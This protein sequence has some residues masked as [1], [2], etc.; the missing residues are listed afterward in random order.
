M[1][2]W[3]DLDTFKWPAGAARKTAA[4]IGNFDGCH[5]G[6]QS[7]IA[8]VRA[9]ADRCAG[10]PVAVTFFPHPAQALTGSVSEPLLFTEEQKTR[11]FG[12]LGLKHQFV[13]KFHAEFAQQSAAAFYENVLRHRLNVQCLIVG[14]EFRF[15]HGRTGTTELLAQWLAR[16][17]LAFEALKPVQFDDGKIGSRG[18]RSLLADHGQVSEAA[19]LLGRPYL[20][21]GTIARG[22]QLG[23]KLGFPTANL[24]AIQQL[25][26]RPGVYAGWVWLGS[27]AA[28]REHPPVTKLPATAL[29]AVFNV[30]VRPTVTGAAQELRVEAH[31]LDQQFAADALYGFRAGF[32][33]TYRLREERRLGSLTELTAQIAADVAEARGLLCSN[34][35]AGA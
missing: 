24:G 10:D 1:I 30:G 33:L 15:G 6:H 2:L 8:A 9:A 3:H 18:I 31:I 16:D 5:V 20:V 13:Q 34:A 19:R 29:P 21:E 14:A 4:T 22:D 26:P 28:Q 23:R 7:L 35:N 27:P 12:E 17:G 25:I 11:A 32:Y